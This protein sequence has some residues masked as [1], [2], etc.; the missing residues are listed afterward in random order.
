MNTCFTRSKMPIRLINEHDLPT[1]RKWKNDHRNF[2][3]F[4]GEISPEQ[5]AEWFRGY[6]TR[7]DDYM[8]M[9]LFGDTEIGCMGI[10]LIDGKWD[11]Y[12]CILGLKEYGKMGLMGKALKEMIALA[13]NL[14]PVPVTSKIL[15]NNDPILNL[16]LRNGFIIESEQPDHYCMLYKGNL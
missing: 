13:V 1:L 16:H 3:F 14:K 8:F 9:V 2:F 7:P 11:W 10:R 12:N 6:R 5:Q 15:I 4:K